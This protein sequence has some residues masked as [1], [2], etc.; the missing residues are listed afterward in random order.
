M[1]KSTRSRRHRKSKRNNLFGGSMMDSASRTGT[2]VLNTMGNTADQ[3]GTGIQ[4]FFTDGY[5]KLF[6]K[7]S[8]TSYVPTGGRRTR[9]GR[10][11]RSRRGG[12]SFPKHL[13][14]F[15][16]PVNYGKG[17]SRSRR[18]G[19]SFPQAL[20]LNA[21]PT[22]LE[23]PIKKGGNRSKRGG[24]YKAMEVRNYGQGPPISG[25]SVPGT[26]AQPH[27]WVGKAQRWVGPSGNAAFLH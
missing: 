1:P 18:G 27:H 24:F 6:K 13:S 17:G 12:F 8:N 19:Y 26:T 9:R 22:T 21:A 2:Q 11:S 10:R 23:M 4:N 25:S 20:S 15:S 14:Q 5:N 16:E 3:A 7:Q